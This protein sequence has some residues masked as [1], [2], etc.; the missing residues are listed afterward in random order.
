MEGAD[1]AKVVAEAEPETRKIANEKTETAIEDVVAEGEEDRA[2][3]AA[4]GTKIRI[5]G[6]SRNDILENMRFAL[7]LSIFC[8]LFSFAE[9]KEIQLFD[10]KSLKGWTDRSGGSPSK[11]WVVEDNCIFRKNK[12]GDLYTKESFKDFDFSFEWKIAVGC[13]SGVKYRV[14]DY[15]G[16]I[17]GPEYQII[18]DAKG[19][20]APDHLGATASIYAIKGASADKKLKPPGAFNVSRIVAKGNKLEHWLNDEKVAE[21]EIGSKD[22]KKLHAKSKFKTRPDFGTKSG[23]IMLQEHG[24]Q[25]RFRNLMIRKL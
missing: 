14:S 23:R 2:V 12:A 1:N 16:A 21:I 9:P 15:S 10:G 19:K 20:Y 18:D 7:L 4:R 3:G 11:G 6:R 13:N 8:P 22:W 24:G 5:V 25:V 17:L